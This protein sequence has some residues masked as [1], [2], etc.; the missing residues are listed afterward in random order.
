MQSSFKP[1]LLIVDDEQ[2]TL[3]A[4]R[5]A[6]DDRYDVFTAASRREAKAVL[7][8]QPVEL[9]LTDL[10]L[11]G[12]S[13]MDVLEMARS[14]PKPPQCIMMTAYGSVD[15]AVEAMKRG[16]Y[17][18]VTKPLN[19]DEVE[20][21]L[22][23]A[24]RASALEEENRDL[25]E[26]LAPTGGLDKMLGNTP[27]M[28]ALFNK[29][30]RVAPSKSTVLIEGES[31]TGKELVA[32]AIHKLSGRPADKFVAVNCSALSP[33]LLESELFGHEKGAF[34]GATQRRIGRFEQAS[35]GTLFLDE[36]G[37]IDPMVQVK[38]LRVLAEKKIER[39]GSNDSIPV[40]VRVV[41]AS[42]KR[43]KDLVS[44]GRFREDLF[45]RLNVISVQMP[46]LRERK[47][48]IILLAQS[49]LKEACA[50]NNMKTKR[51]SRETLDV[52]R[53]YNWPGNV[54][55]LRTAVEHGVIMAEGE[56]IA[57]SDLPTLSTEPTQKPEDKTDDDFKLEPSPDFNLE[58]L[59]QKTIQ[60]A[61]RHTGGNRNAAAKL[62]GINRRTLQRKL[63]EYSNTKP[64]QNS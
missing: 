28:V 24:Y 27:Q 13:G 41:A 22:M 60:A 15:T 14:L 49:F 64:Q 7:D 42:N 4:L 32:N 53:A 33:Q 19:L 45:F 63:N 39:V 16:A 20:M 30:K 31:G 26:R 52:L 6:L 1:I 12:D 21:L 44:A 37:E 35:G 56:I 25:H 48:D 18:F 62:L 38:L 57:P 8:S 55:Q 17:T 10:R 54:R 11:G 43:L 47:D 58:L 29:I 2:A 9:V 40:N 3:Q 34:T 50:E 36:I 61:L 5:M 46:P 59:E 23:R 51:F